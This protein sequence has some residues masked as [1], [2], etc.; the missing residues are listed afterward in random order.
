MV[1][2]M[3]TE[4]WL[5]QRIFDLLPRLR[6]TKINVDLDDVGDDDT[7]GIAVLPAEAVDLNKVQPVYSAIHP[8]AGDLRQ[9]ARG[10]LSTWYPDRAN[11]HE[12][13]GVLCLAITR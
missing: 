7:V 10:F 11:C 9:I 8:T 1:R 2:S 4:R 3:T 13:H 5:K 12:S 6:Y